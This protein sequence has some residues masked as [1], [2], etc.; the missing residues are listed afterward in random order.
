M[1][2]TVPG[3]DRMTVDP[4]VLGG[5]PTI[6]GMRLSVEGVLDILA[7]NPSWVEFRADV[8]DLESEDV[9]Q[10]LRFAAAEAA[11]VHPSLEAH[12]V[13]RKPRKA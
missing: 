4:E 6:R 8:L 3:F 11:S 12:S 2:T 10:A 7:Q 13:D 5:T 1:V 9:D